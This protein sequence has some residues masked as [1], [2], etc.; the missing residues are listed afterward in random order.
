M[1]E[2]KKQKKQKVDR[3]I[4]TWPKTLPECSSAQTPGVLPAS[5]PRLNGQKM[6]TLQYVRLHNWDLGEMVDI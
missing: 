2:K 5:L 3:Q 1:W 6:S 4:S